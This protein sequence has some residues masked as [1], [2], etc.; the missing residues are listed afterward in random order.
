MHRVYIL[1]QDIRG[2]QAIIRDKKIIHHLKDVLRL[3]KGDMVTG[4]NEEG[5]EYKCLIEKIEDSIILGIRERQVKKNSA[6]S[7]TI[8]CAIPKNSRFEDIVDK[9]TQLGVSKIIPLVTQRTIVKIDKKKEEAK[10]ARWRKVAIQAAQQSRRSSLPLIDK[11]EN[12]RQV[13]EGAGEYDLKLIPTLA[14]SR[15]APR[16]TLGD[17]KPKSALVLIGPEGDFSEE[18]VKMALKAGCIP[19]TLGD[20]VLRVEAAAA[21]VAGFIK[22]YYENH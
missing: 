22:L 14:G 2:S 18:E 16:E 4:F 6:L 19:V 21:A 15:K 3:K 8:A 10:L 9:L 20:L 17:K 11:I 5:N 7:I 13:L 12:M 1:S